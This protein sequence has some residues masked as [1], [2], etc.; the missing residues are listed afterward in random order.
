[1]GQLVELT[2]DEQS[3]DDFDDLSDRAASLAGV[4]G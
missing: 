4:R 3:E 2:I 1:M